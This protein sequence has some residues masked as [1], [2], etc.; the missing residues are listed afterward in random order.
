MNK[1]KAQYVLFNVDH[2][3]YLTFIDEG[4]FL[5]SDYSESKTFLDKQA[6]IDYLDVNYYKISSDV[7]GNWTTR[8]FFVER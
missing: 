2:N 4:F 6:A 8:E 5:T 1:I 7:E 3:M